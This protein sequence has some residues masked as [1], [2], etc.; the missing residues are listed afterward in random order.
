MAEL[1]ATNVCVTGM[2][3]VYELSIYSQDYSC[4]YDGRTEGGDA[5]DAGTKEVGA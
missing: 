4:V 2:L 3:P 1:G 5:V